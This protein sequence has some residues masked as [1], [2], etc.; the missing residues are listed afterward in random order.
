MKVAIPIWEGKVSPLFD[1]ASKVLVFDIEDAKAVLRFQTTLG[2]QDL[3]RRC[4]RLKGL[5]VELLICGAISWQL[6]DILMGAGIK[7]IPWISGQ[8]DEVI[9]AYIEGRLNDARYLMPGCEEAD[10]EEM[11]RIFN[12]R[13][14]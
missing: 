2:E 3:R 14:E 8:T 10:K 1:T 4:S 11:D 12:K 6:R 13:S 5:G 9:Q 7:V